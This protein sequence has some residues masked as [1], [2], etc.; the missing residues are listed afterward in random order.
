MSMRY[1]ARKAAVCILAAGA[2]LG[3]SPAFAQNHESNIRGASAWSKGDNATLSVKDTE[4]DKHGVYAR[5]FRHNNGGEKRLNNY[6][7]EGTT[8]TSASDAKHYVT[9]LKACVDI[10]WGADRCDGSWQLTED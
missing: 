9:Q 1:T 2:I 6:A 7:G 8:T 5:Y 10:Q 4:A 3:A